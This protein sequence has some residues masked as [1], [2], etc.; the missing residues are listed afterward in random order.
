MSD[1]TNKRAYAARTEVPVWRSK[2]AISSDLKRLGA[3][4]EAFYAAPGRAVIVFEIGE[5]RY[6]LSVSMPSPDDYRYDARGYTRTERQARIAFEQDE[7]ERWRALVAYVKSLRI[8]AEAGIIDIREA[9]LSNVVLANGETVGEFLL[10]Q[11]AEAAAAERMPPLLPGVTK[12][13]EMPAATL[14]LPAARIREEE[15]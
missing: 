2:D 4:R 15:E 6:R 5:T 11:L 7:R 1:T 3:Q 14:R 10:P 12:R 9:L 13:P 8:A